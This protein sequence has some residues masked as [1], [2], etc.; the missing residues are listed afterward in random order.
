MAERFDPYHRWL[1]IPPAEQPPNHYRLLA[2]NPFEDNLDVIE[3]AADQRM[4]H[5]RTFQSGRHGKLSQ[6]LL[7]EVAAARICLLDPGKRALY[8][9]Q[10][11]VSLE[12][13]PVPKAVPKKKRAGPRPGRREKKGDPQVGSLFVGEQPTRTSAAGRRRSKN[14]TPLIIGG[15]AAALLLIVVVLA[16][17]ISSGPDEPVSQGPQPPGETADVSPGGEK[18]DEPGRYKIVTDDEHKTLAGL[19]HEADDAAADDLASKGPS[20]GPVACYDFSS[21][22]RDKLGNYDGE[23]VGDAKVVVDADRGNVLSLDGK[24]DY[25]QI[26]SVFGAP[27]SATLTAWVNA[28]G[29]GG[30]VV[31]LADSLAL[32]VGTK[33]I[34]GFFHHGR[35]MSKWQQFDNR[36]NIVGTGWRHI[37]LT[38]DDDGNSQKL[39]LDGLPA[40]SGSNGHPIQYLG[41]TTVIGRHAIRNESA[42]QGKIDD[43]RIYNRPLAPHEIAA[44]A[45]LSDATIAA[46]PPAAPGLVFHLPFD[47]DPDSSVG[48]FLGSLRG[49]ASIVTDPIRGNVLSLDGRGDWVLLPNFPK[50]KN[51]VT[52]AAWVYLNRPTEWASIMKN[53]GE[54]P[55]GLFHFG[56]TG[57]GGCLHVKLGTAAGA[58]DARSRTPLS[59]GRWH[60]VAFT[61]DGSVLRLYEDGRQVA[62]TPAPGALATPLVQSVA[63]GAKTNDAGTGLPRMR[64]GFFNGRIDDVRLYDRALS[65][66]EIA[67]LAVVEEPPAD[68][69]ATT[70]PVGVPVN[71]P[72]SPR[73]KPKPAGSDKRLPVPSAAEQAKILPL[74]IEAFELEPRKLAAAE[75]KALS[76]LARSVLTEAVNTKDEPNTQYVMLRKACELASDVGDLPAALEAVDELGKRFRAD[77]TAMRIHVTRTAL[78]ANIPPDV[79]EKMVE[80]ALPVVDEAIAADKYDDAEKMTSSLLKLAGRISDRSYTQQVAQRRKL[81][82]SKRK[83]YA[84]VAAALKALKVDAD[85]PEANATVGIHLCM[86]KNRWDEGLAML[87]KGNNPKLKQA[88][89][90][91]QGNPSDPLKQ[92]EVGE[93]WH[94]AAEDLPDDVKMACLDRAKSWYERCLPKLPGL[95]KVKAQKRLDKIAEAAKDLPQAKAAGP[96]FPCNGLLAAACDYRCDI[97]INGSIAGYASSS[98]PAKLARVFNAGDTIIVRVRRSTGRRA[99]ACAI[100]LEGYPRMIVTGA[101]GSGWMS[102]RPTT[103]YQWYAPGGTVAGPAVAAMG[104]S[105]QVVST[106]AGVPCG[107]IWSS[108]EDSPTSSYSYAYLILQFPGTPPAGK[109]APGAAPAA[110]GTSGRPVPQ[111]PKEVPQPPKPAPTT[112]GLVAHWKLDEG[113]GTRALDASGNGHHGTLVGGARWSDGRIGKALTFDGKDDYVRLGNPRQLNFRGPITMAAWVLLPRSPTSQHSNI[114]AHGFIREPKGNVYLRVTKGSLGRRSYETGAWDGTDHRAFA[115]MSSDNSDGGTWTHLAGVSDGTRWFLYRNGAHLVTQESRVG[116]IPVNGDWAIGARGD[117]SERFFRG[118]IDDV[119]IYNRALSA[120]EIKVLGASATQ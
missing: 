96:K 104:A 3:S 39:Y 92:L 46:K 109:A 112:K 25:V 73:P 105:S 84:K 1:G 101:R 90:Q 12:A 21:G 66:S 76:E 81:I 114:L 118:S 7:N 116:A 40:A 62:G 38:F 33:D 72:P 78:K 68:I 111:T 79:R 36:R 18:P 26:P 70:D 29:D 32:R 58:V 16:A 107:A 2:V 54:R 83:S 50:P 77:P 27:G 52:G 49:D 98:T 80:L 13:K 113:S 120:E 94:D 30:G 48:R 108:Q 15:A 69:A 10:L 93:G 57:M 20:E 64:K 37:A 82:A 19:M 9:K 47:S 34:R 86:R 99:F 106:L 115:T 6:K 5:L 31:S 97:A 51:A 65:A 117:G 43:V 56:L 8:D 74:V 4:A 89:V 63:I 88:A 42:F 24:G 17:I 59:T 67:A 28:D 35:G 91:E 23:F 110:V 100:K 87:V 60:H 55:I 119:R 22:A 61:A 103:T 85:D 45:G 44:L 75:P 71:P 102:Y 53:W 11:R 41:A 95:H 14:Q